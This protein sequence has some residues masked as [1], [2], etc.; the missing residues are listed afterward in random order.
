MLKA[1]VTNS[2]LAD[3]RFTDLVLS[4]TKQTA[5]AKD[6]NGTAGLRPAPDELREDINRLRRL[7]EKTNPDR[8]RDFSV[9]MDGIMYRCAVIPAIDGDWY[10]L[11]RGVD[12]IPALEAL[13]YPKPL[14][15]KLVDP[16][17]KDG[18]IVVSG[19]QR[20][21]KTTTASALV[22]DR[23][24]L[25][26]G[27]AITLENPPELPLSGPHGSGICFQI[28]VNE[29]DG[30]AFSRGLV[31][32]MRYAEPDMIMLGELRDSSAASQALRAAI[33]G[34]LIVATLH[35]SGVEET[36]TRIR[37]MARDSDGA[38]VD[39]LLADGLSCV[40]HQSMLQ[41]AKGRRSDI[42]FLFTDN[43]VRS[44]IRAGRINQLGTD[45]QYQRNRLLTEM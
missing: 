18:L 29:G 21:G 30:D 37:A 2:R 8:R 27:H 14:A 20:A 45:I 39:E 11:R 6:L 34:H 43:Q 10:A 23:L 17:L 4:C 13:G 32:A 16:T 40:L 7:I 12:A 44:K 33:N 36:L 25:H 26:G 5:F 19:A 38:I 9:T 24:L 15:R 35:A 41:D 42:A 31:H 1:M 3:L 28:D 22:R